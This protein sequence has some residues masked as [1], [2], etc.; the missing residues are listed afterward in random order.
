MAES[1]FSEFPSV[2]PAEWLEQAAKDLKGRKVESLAWTT[3]DGISLFPILTADDISG[4]QVGVPSHG[5]GQN[6][7]KIHHDFLMPD[8]VTVCDLLKKEKNFSL[9]SVGLV[10]GGAIRR[11]ECSPW[12]YYYWNP[13]ILV[14]DTRT[15]QPLVEAVDREAELHITAGL[16]AFPVFAGLVR[17]LR[18]QGRDLKQFTGGIDNNP[19]RF[20]M[21]CGSFPFGADCNLGNTASIVRFAASNMPLFR[22]LQVSTEPIHASGGTPAQEIAL[23]LSMAVEYFEQLGK[24][25]ITP[26]EAIS[27][28]HFVFETGTGFFTEIAKL[29][30]FRRLWNRI[31]AAYGLKDARPLSIRAKSSAFTHSHLDPQVNLLRT[32]TQAMSAVMGGADVVAV[33]EFDQ[34]SPQDHSFSARI[35]RNVQLLL[36]HEAWMGKVKDP[37]AGAYYPEKLT[38]ALEEKAWSLFL[39]IESEGGFLQSFMQCKVQKRIWKAGDEKEERIHSGKDKYIG[40]NHYANPHESPAHILQMS[41]SGFGGIL[42]QKPDEKLTLALNAEVKE[43]VEALTAIIAD[44]YTFSDVVESLMD[45]GRQAV[46]MLAGKRA[47]HDFEMLR[48]GTEFYALNNGHRPQ[49]HLFLF[50]NPAMR[51][52]RAAFAGNLFAAAGFAVTESDSLETCFP[53]SPEVIVFCSDDAGY[54][55]QVPALIQSC[56]TTLPDT[57][58]VLA[59]K[60][61]GSEAWLSA[62]LHSRIH[63]GMDI[64]A[65]LVHLQ[66]KLGM[67]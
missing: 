42:E 58:L 31:L 49:V 7:W 2:T 51:K 30:A 41:H 4:L 20:L 43:R 38:S 5:G 17:C 65:Y 52:A 12:A 59:G 13:G 11:Q 62:G 26:R 9:D 33:S 3:E 22:S 35:A 24:Y 34:V 45:D 44:G 32:T 21:K 19:F 47:S 67:L 14:P 15:L 6:D 25:D 55:A 37:A 28:L 27:Q 40:V 18:E 60:P 39:E 36:R 56:K 66:R 46:P 53:A 8:P 16:G 10:L 48:R 1:L 50:G 64:S 23:A 54:P 61:E 57:L 63:A 29:R